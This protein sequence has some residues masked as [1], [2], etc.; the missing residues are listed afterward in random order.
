MDPQKPSDD[1][2][3]HYALPNRNGK[4][5]QPL[6]GSLQPVTPVTSNSAADLI[7]SKLDTLYNDEPKAKE[8][9]TEAEAVKHRS[10]HQQFM[11]DL[12]NSG[13]SLA[14]I[15]TAWHQYY[16]ALP[17]N[18]KHEVWQEFY[19]NHNQA[20]TTTPESVDPEPTQ[21]TKKPATTHKKKTK[22][23]D[24]RSLH[25][26]K[27]ELLG[28]VQ[29]R[30]KLT[31]KDHL[32]SLMFGLSM[33][34][35]TLFILLFG[36]FNERFIAP[37]ITP[38]RAVSQTPII[39]DPTNAAVSS[40]PKIIIPKINVEIPV[41]YDEPTINEAAIQRA[42]EKGVVHYPTTSNP[43]EIGNG[44]IFGHSANNILNHGKYKF[45]FVLLKRLEPGDTFYIQKD[46]K[47]YAYKVFDKKIVPP[48]DVSVLYPSFPE[49]PATFTLITCDPP[50]TSLNRLV[51]TGEQVTPDPKNNAAS[52]ATHTN[53]QPKILPSN[54]ETLWQ[55][56]KNWF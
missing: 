13:K 40:D 6:D 20:R 50:G 43:G 52:T 27:Q 16:V 24:T 55:R 31:H 38:S 11:Y 22:R 29:T 48:T 47:R 53:T 33:G 19:A 10:K 54:S 23:P 3:N 1:S 34:L 32:R 51:V 46:G 26:V 4:V 15:Q 2:D 25:E 49:K 12:S 9:L 44:V 42:L 56:I 21:P 14:E 17:N 28:K 5:I 37:F 7:R 35:L 30:R 45:A 36:L 8:E 18:E 39:I 41:I